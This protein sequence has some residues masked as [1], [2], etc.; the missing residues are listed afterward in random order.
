LN[1]STDVYWRDLSQLYLIR[2]QE[3][4]QDPS[5]T[6]EQRVDLTQVI[7][8]SAVNASEQAIDI[9]PNNVANWSVRGFVYR[10]LIGLVG[11][12]EN[13]AQESYVMAIEL[14][15]TNPYLFTEVG[16]VYALQADVLGQ[17]GQEELRQE[18]LDLAL[19]HFE[20]AIGLKSDYAPAQFRIALVYDRQGRIVEAINILEQTK[21]VA[22]FDVGLA[23]QLGLLYY[24]NGD[25]ENAQAELERAIS[26]NENY[27]NARY[28]LGLIH[29]QKG[30]KTQ[31]IEQFMQIAALN[32]DNEL[33]MRILENLQGGKS[34]LA[35]LTPPVLPIQEV[36]PERL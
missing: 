13:L 18:V 36:P 19:Q 2:L 12:A 7:I 10:N 14:E 26:L 28:F 15:P 20:K 24:R 9:N 22:P 33:V 21:Q 31:A 5:L 11:G 3:I 6:E 16:I 4:L 8:S 1:P 30:R 25:L 35:G 27:S 34:A 32:P 17:Q 29:D 23:F